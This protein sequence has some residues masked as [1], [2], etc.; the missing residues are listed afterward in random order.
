MIRDCPLIFHV[1]LFQSVLASLLPLTLKSSFLQTSH[2]IQCVLC[3]HFHSLRKSTSEMK[4]PGAPWV[5][6]IS[7]SLIPALKRLQNPVW[8]TQGDPHKYRKHVFFADSASGGKKRATTLTL[9]LC[10]LQYW[11]T[12]ILIYQV[13]AQL[14][15]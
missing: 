7:C 2:Q 14:N 3:I 4:A 11:R 5:L 10:L 6:F 1:N 8:S 15:S 9:I 13:F 12:L